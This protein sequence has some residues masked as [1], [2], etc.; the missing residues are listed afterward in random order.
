M[1]A[2]TPRETCSH[3]LALIFDRHGGAAV[4][5]LNSLLDFKDYLRLTAAELITRLLS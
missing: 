4:D 3:C 1:Q 5:L 2:F